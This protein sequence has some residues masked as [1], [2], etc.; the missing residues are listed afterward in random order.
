MKNDLEKIGFTY[1]LFILN[2]VDEKELPLQYEEL[3]REIKKVFKY[4]IKTD[5]T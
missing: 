5:N 3:C 2:K 1:I 4:L